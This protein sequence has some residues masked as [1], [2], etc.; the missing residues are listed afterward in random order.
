MKIPTQYIYEMND[1]LNRDLDLVL[2][3]QHYRSINS[4]YR[5]FHIV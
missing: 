2:G 1:V 5:C 4:P 3:L